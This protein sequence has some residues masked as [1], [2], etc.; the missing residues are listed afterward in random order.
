MTN[1]FGM[2]VV[3]IGA[4]RQGL[5]LARYL[6][7]QRAMVILNDQRMPAS[8][9]QNGLHWL[10]WMGRSHGFAVN[11]PS[12]WQLAPTW[13]APPAACRSACR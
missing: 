2:R 11:T 1:W 9:R 8:L 10:A 13:F 12:A 4:A 5:A 6:A 7:E 3:I